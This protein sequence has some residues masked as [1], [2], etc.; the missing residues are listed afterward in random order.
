M[1]FS[2]N[3]IKSRY[4]RFLN[5]EK[6]KTD[7][8]MEISEEEEAHDGKATNLDQHRR[9]SIEIS[10]ES[11]KQQEIEG[12]IHELNE[13]KG[14]SIETAYSDFNYWKPA[15]DLNFEDLLEEIKK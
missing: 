3:E 4:L 5:L 14:N 15:V 11:K 10:E 8:S 13:L 2:L 6:E 7:P 1:D 12:D 9:S